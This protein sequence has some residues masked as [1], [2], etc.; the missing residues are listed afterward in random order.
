M[1]LS[2]AS[3]SISQ[4]SVVK[5]VKNALHLVKYGLR[6]NLLRSFLLTIYI[7]EIIRLHFPF[8]I[9]VLGINNINGFFILYF[10]NFAEICYI[11]ELG[12]EGVCLR[13]EFDY[14]VVG[15]GL[16]LFALG[17]FVSLDFLLLLTI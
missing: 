6:K 7:G 11:V 10:H 5:S 1:S 17:I 14:F 16:K 15:R 3:N 8:H 4:N 9:F 12:V 13:R 2:G